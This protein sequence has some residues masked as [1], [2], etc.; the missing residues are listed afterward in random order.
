[1]R[2][3][4]IQ[5]LAVAATAGLALSLSA[6]GH[7]G[8]TPLSASAV[9]AIIPSRVPV[10]LPVDAPE[11]PAHS[12]PA[13]AKPGPASTPDTSTGTVS[14]AP[15]AAPTA[16]KTPEPARE[17]TSRPAGTGSSAKASPTAAPT[18]APKA[19]APSAASAA[20][21]VAASPT[22]SVPAAA[23]SAAAA[24]AAA[25]LTAYRGV[26]I[27]YA[28]PDGYPGAWGT[29]SAQAI[30]VYPVTPA[31]Y[32]TSVTMHEYIHVL[33]FRAGWKDVASTHGE[34]VADAGEQLLGGSYFKYTNGAPTAAEQA[35]ARA[36]LGG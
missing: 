18:A 17:T 22:T 21:P 13:S 16:V 2:A 12:T 28:D 7:T 23:P 33:E 31:R 32:V 6:C 29:A 19:K 9:V 4:T 15:T 1:M 27:I 36:L 24:P 10:D 3:R 34:R 20:P 30:W 35:E 5:G 26:P 25:R 11:T 8:V 14:A